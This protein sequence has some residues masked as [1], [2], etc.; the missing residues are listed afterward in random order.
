MSED[1][2][3]SKLV[4][5]RLL[6]SDLQLG[7]VH[8]MISVVPKLD[9]QYLNKWAVILRVDSALEKAKYNE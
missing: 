2:I 3:L 7:D 9:W 8:H 4:W 1:L 5:A 6:Q